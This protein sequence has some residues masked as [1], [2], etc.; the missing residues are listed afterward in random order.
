MLRILVHNWWLLALR[1]AFA[2]AFAVIVFSLRV[3][4]STWLLQVIAF[5]SVVEL[6]GLFA[7]LSG[8]FTLMAA[9]RGFSKESSWWLLFLDGVAVCLGGLAAVAVPDLS[10]IT[11][12]RVI[13]FWAL[14][15][16]ACEILMARKLRHHLP[17]EWF[18]VLSGIGSAAFSIFLL[19]GWTSQVRQ[20]IL[21]L[22]FYAL[23]SSFTM[24]ALAFRLLKLRSLAHQAARHAA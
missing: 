15:V 17:D 3:F 1:G 22:G 10:F 14:L 11:L 21:W 4:G 19:L 23:F 18:L 7:F 9:A 6:F 2:L 16:G 5:T 20:L 13:G 12:V 8:L 24:L